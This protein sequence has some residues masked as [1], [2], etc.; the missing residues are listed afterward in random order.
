VTAIA[1]RVWASNQSGGLK[2]WNMKYKLYRQGQAAK[3]EKAIPYQRFIEE[4]VTLPT[5]RNIA[6]T[7]RTI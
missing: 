4:A 3:S 1:A 2:L 7:G 6:A 5:V